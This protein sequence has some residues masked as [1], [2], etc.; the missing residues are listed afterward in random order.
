M[1]LQILLIIIAFP[2]G[3]LIAYMARDELIQGRKWFVTLSILS[4]V[5]S[6]IAFSYKETTIGFASLFIIISTAVSYYKSF[7]KKWTRK[8]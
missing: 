5:V 7:D 6:V 3:L 1:I 8:R 4:A 2:V